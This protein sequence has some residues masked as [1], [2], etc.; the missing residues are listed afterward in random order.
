MWSR[1]VGPPLH[2]LPVRDAPDHDTAELDF[3]VRLAVGGF[4]GVPND[5]PIALRDKA[6]SDRSRSEAR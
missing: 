5:D 2:K 1:E 3:L 6:E 4:L